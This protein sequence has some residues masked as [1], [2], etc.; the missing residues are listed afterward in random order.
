MYCGVMYCG[1]MYCG[2][3][4]ATRHRFRV[5][6]APVRERGEEEVKISPSPTRSYQADTAQ[7]TQESQEDILPGL[8]S[9]LIKVTHS[10]FTITR[11]EYEETLT[12]LAELVNVSR[13][14]RTTLG[15]SGI[16]FAHSE[17]NQ[18]LPGI[19]V[20]LLSPTYI[21][22]SHWSSSYITA[23]SLVE[24]FRVFLRQLSYAIKNQL[25]ASKAPY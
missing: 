3:V 15:R 4:A 2:I 19:T 17:W 6:T 20:R 9:G 7:R 11:A 22:D 14:M 25:V 10:V 21:Q 18:P 12:S 24:S 16:L 1:V 23:L 5:N 8:R 13:L